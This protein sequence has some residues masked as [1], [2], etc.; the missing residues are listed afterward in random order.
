[1]NGAVSRPTTN[2][3]NVLAKFR[4]RLPDIVYSN[5]LVILT[6][7]QSHTVKFHSHDLGLPPTC[8]EYY[9][10]N[11]AFSSDPDTWYTQTKTHLIQQF[12]ISMSTINVI[13]ETLCK[14]EPQPLAAFKDMNDDRSLI[15]R[16][17]RD[18]RLTRMDLRKLQDGSASFEMS[19]NIHALNAE[20]FRDF[21]RLESISV[22]PK[23]CSARQHY[24][25]R[26]ILRKVSTNIQE[27]VLG[28]KQHY[29]EA[30][31]GKAEAE[32]KCKDLQ[33]MKQVI[34]SE[35]QSQ[36]LKIEDTV[37][38]LREISTS[39]NVAAEL[40]DFIACPKREAQTLISSS[41]IKKLE[42]SVTM[43][44]GLCNEVGNDIP[45]QSITTQ[46]SPEY[47]SAPS[48]PLVR[49]H[50]TDEDAI[51]SNGSDTKKLRERTSL[52]QDQQFFHRTSNPDR[53]QS[54]YDQQIHLKQKEEYD[55]PTEPQLKTQAGFGESMY[56]SCTLA[57]LIETSRNCRDRTMTRELRLRTLGKSIGVLSAAEQIELCEQVVIHR[58]KQLAELVPLKEDLQDQIRHEINDDVFQIGNVHPAK[59]LQLAAINL[60]IDRAIKDSSV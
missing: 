29:R 60:L 19:S 22:G 4:E 37:Q 7:C 21:T 30:R 44:E 17:L 16:E 28:L 39:F 56:K 35:L 11:S 26:K 59:I 8:Y 14:I 25:D 18:A 9:M 51:N 27:V 42:K 48:S 13:V 57:E 52:E 55:T 2:I 49:N 1:M 32:M 24:D 5:M 36:Y 45:T 15:Q 50:T 40:F 47:V 33:D 6:N 12:N 53:E 23:R 10:Q 41:V 3:E 34:A 38:R 43:I 58:Q 46:S 31:A 20:D 54:A